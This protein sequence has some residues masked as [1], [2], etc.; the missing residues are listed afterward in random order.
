[1]KDV[2]SWHPKSFGKNSKGMFLSN[3][4]LAAWQLLSQTSLP[5]FHK[6]NQD[7]QGAI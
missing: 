3:T 7:M 5:F 2:L 1:M 6:E 4:T